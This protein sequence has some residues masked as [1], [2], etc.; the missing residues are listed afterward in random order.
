MI[1]VMFLIAPRESLME[2][3]IR[4]WYFWVSGSFLAVGSIVFREFWLEKSYKRFFL[5]RSWLFPAWIS[6]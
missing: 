5:V 1:W 3:R 6:F 4:D 2:T